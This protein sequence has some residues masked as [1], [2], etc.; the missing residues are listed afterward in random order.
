MEP[1]A[2]PVK[3]LK[4]ITSTPIDAQDIDGASRY[5]EQEWVAIATHMNA[6]AMWLGKK[7]EVADGLN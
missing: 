4:G 2:K 6:D 7:A 1:T 5:I 3:V